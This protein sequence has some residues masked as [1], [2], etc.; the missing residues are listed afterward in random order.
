MRENGVRIRRVRLE[1]QVEDCEEHTGTQK[2]PHC[3]SLKEKELQLSRGKISTLTKFNMKPLR[4]TVDE[5]L[6]SKAA[7]VVTF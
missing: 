2:E 6:S 5:T 3:N 7:V 1:S 4:L